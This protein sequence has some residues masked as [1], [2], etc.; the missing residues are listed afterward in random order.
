MPVGAPSVTT[1]NVSRYCQMS[2]EK[3]KPFFAKSYSSREK[4][5]I[6]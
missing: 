2:L 4:K 5:I 1:K 3:V 6:Y